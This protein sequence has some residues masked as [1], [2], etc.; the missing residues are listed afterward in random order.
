MEENIE[1]EK[2]MLLHKAS[3]VELPKPGVVTKPIE[4]DTLNSIPGLVEEETSDSK[5]RF[6]LERALSFDTDEVDKNGLKHTMYFLF[7]GDNRLVATSENEHGIHSGTIYTYDEQG[8]LVEEERTWFFS[9]EI[10]KY[11]YTSENPTESGAY[12][13]DIKKTTISGLRSK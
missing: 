4:F 13:Y 5:K 2:D 7:D 3:P 10:F 6:G 11:K 12:P 8:K 1:G 9:T